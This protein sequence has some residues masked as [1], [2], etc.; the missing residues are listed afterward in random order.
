MSLNLGA[1]GG[2]SSGFTTIYSGKG[3]ISAVKVLNI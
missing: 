2:A 1:K 3:G